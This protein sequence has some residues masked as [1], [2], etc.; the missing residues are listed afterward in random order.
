MRFFGQTD[1]FHAYC[2]VYVEF[3]ESQSVGAALLKREIEIGND[4]LEIKKTKRMFCNLWKKTEKINIDEI[5]LQAP[6]ESSP[7]NIVNT[8]ND[9]CLTEIFTY[10]SFQDQCSVLGVCVRFNRIA[11]QLL[12]KV[13]AKHKKKQQHLFHWI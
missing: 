4:V 1:L 7:K 6:D 9:D 3:Y 2:C 10:L 12:A 5:L 8:L 11:K 13:G